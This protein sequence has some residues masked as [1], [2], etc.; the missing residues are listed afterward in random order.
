MSSM[1][2][3]SQ[4]ELSERHSVASESGSST[5]SHADTPESKDG[6]SLPTRL[7]LLL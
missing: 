3:N 4:G 6:E 5:D 1:N 2:L 7:L